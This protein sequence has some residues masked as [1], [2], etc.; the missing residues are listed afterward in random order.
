M[1]CE[2][3]NPSNKK[4]AEIDQTHLDF[5]KSDHTT[6]H[7]IPKTFYCEPTCRMNTLSQRIRASMQ[8][9]RSRAFLCSFRQISVDPYQVGRAEHQTEEIPWS[10]HLPS[11]KSSAISR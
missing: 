7:Y 9:L 2:A 5:F 6:S 10:I 3:M 1:A 11:Y 8:G 4:I